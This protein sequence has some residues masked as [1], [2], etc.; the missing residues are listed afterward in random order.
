MANANSILTESAVDCGCM[1]AHRAVLE[2]HQ[3]AVQEWARHILRECAPSKRGF[4]PCPAFPV[5]PTVSRACVGPCA[6]T[7]GACHE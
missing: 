6:R 5:A 7:M 2:Q 3:A 4:V 1:M